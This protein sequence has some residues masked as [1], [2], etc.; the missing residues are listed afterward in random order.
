[1]H[2]RTNSIQLKLHNLKPLFK[3]AVE[4]NLSN[5]FLGER[6]L[7]QQKWSLLQHI[8]T[9]IYY[10]FPQREP[11]CETCLS[12]TV[13]TTFVFHFHTA[14]SSNAQLD[15]VSALHLFQNCICTL[16]N[17]FIIMT[18]LKNKV[19]CQQKF[20]LQFFFSDPAGPPYT[21]ISEEIQD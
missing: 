21:Y 8:V 3:H 20:Y 7:W 17:Y 10:F 19:P 16:R 11:K 13:K 15:S 6:T 18:F 9:I 5:I 2:S 1:M 12:I 14:Y 4:D